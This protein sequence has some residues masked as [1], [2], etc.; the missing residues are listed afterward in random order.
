MASSSQHQP[1][2]TAGSTPLT[3]S[4]DGSSSAAPGRVLAHAAGAA[5]GTGQDWLLLEMVQPAGKRP[6]PIQAFLNGNAG[7]VGSD[8]TVRA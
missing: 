8:L 5:I 1:N 2:C 7:F 3:S 6:M 4:R